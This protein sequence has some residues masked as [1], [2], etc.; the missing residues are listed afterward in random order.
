[1]IAIEDINDIVTRHKDIYISL[2]ADDA[3]IFTKI[4][5]IN[6]VREKFLEILQEINSWGATSGASLA[7]EKCQTL[8]ICRKQR[9]NLS[10]IVFN[11]RTIKDVNFLKILGITFDSKLLF[12]QHCQTLRKQLETRF[13]IIKFLSSKY[14]YIHIKT[15][16]DITRALM[17][18]KIDYGLPIFGW[19]AKSHLKKLQV[20][21][22]GAV[23]RAI[24]AF[25]TSP[26]ACTLAESGLPS[27]QSRVEETTL[28]LI[29]KLYT[30][31][32]CL[33]TKD[34]GAIFKQKRK[35]KCISTLRRCANYIKLLDLPLPKPRRPF[36]SP[37]LWGSK[38]PNINLQIYN[39]AKKDTGRLEYQKR[40]M[41]AQEDLGVKNWI[42]TD[43]SKVTGA[44]TFAVVDSNRKIIAGGRLP[45]YNSI[46]TAEAFAILKACQFASKN[47]GKSVICTDSLSS[48]SAIRNWNHNDP[49]TQEVRHILSSHP[50]KITLLWVPSHQGIH[51]NEL[52]DKAAQEMRLTPSILFTPF[53]SKDLKS[54][55]KL[56]LKEKK[57]SEWALF[58]HRYQSIN[59]NCIMFK[60]P[61][62]VHKRECATFI[63]LRIGH[64]QSTH[65]HLLMRSARPTCQLCGDELTVDHILNACSQLH[66]IRSHL[67]GTHSLSNCLSIPSCE[68]ISKI[69]KFV[70][71][72]KFII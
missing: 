69:Y 34:F 51:G 60:P 11:S 29:P 30:T 65:Q 9:C 17:L 23:R 8:H 41:S 27:I 18:S 49:T 20:P 55:I 62:N 36:K 35:F 13:N 47:A 63:R 33:L 42:Y 64:T 67:F 70:Q 10:D 56:Y 28:M 48:L 24:H 46:F 15:L 1:M 37:A 61:T 26:V 19:C 40:F 39:A 32:N 5:N 59:P 4:K 14:S 7:I 45:S 31:S 38:Q 52:A 54:R 71:K 2:Y 68:N 58:M 21:Y 25:P 12:K 6:T 57:L 43:G 22:H 66:S 44:T 3:I 72:A 53:N 16:I 50:K